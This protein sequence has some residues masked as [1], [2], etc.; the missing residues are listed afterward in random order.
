VPAVDCDWKTIADWE[1][2]T[3]QDPGVIDH[4]A[5]L[6]GDTYARTCADGTVWLNAT[7]VFA[8]LNVP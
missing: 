1:A 4:L 3:A 6:G 2:L 8:F 5:R 7:M